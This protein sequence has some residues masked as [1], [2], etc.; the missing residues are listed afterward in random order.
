MDSLKVGIFGQF[1]HPDAEVYIGQLLETLDKEHI[2]VF[3]ENN[4]SNAVDKKNPSQSRLLNYPTFKKLDSSFNL[5]FS[6]GGDGTML[7]AVSAI[8]DLKIPLAGINTGRLG[9]LASIPKESIK[10]SISEIINGKYAIS[11][12]SLLD[13]SIVPEEVSLKKLNFALNDI[14]VIRK[15]TT[16]MIKIEAFLNGEYL[17]TYWSDGLIVST[18]TGSTAYSL[19]CGGPILMPTT[20]SFIITPISVHN[21]NVRPVVIPDDTVIKLKISGRDDKYLMSL[22]S[23]TT[24]LP[25]HS[26]ITI[27][28]SPFTVN[29]I[30]LHNE[31]FIKTLRK[32]LLWGEDKRN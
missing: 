30:Q 4:F 14:S 20:D 22:D 29:I 25:N 27:K 11:E 24:V 23:R 16:S 15:N 13:I 7:H 28:K 18:P 32:K 1:Y 6:I 17:T 31:S 21:L 10:K 5:L 19:S 9:F 8:K 3:I 2:S 26:E 12:R